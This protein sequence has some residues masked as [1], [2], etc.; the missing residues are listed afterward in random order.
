MPEPYLAL[1]ILTYLGC[2]LCTEF[3]SFPGIVKLPRCIQPRLRALSYWPI[4]APTLV[5][6]D[7]PGATLPGPSAEVRAGYS[8]SYTARRLS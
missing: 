1:E 6:P 2:I 8:Q 7:G 4:T 5:L 3:L